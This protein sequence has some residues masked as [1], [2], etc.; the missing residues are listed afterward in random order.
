MSQ[1]R[2]PFM[3]YYRIRKQAELNNV[4]INQRVEI[5][6]KEVVTYDDLYGALEYSLQRLYDATDGVTDVSST[7]INFMLQVLVDKK[8]LTDKELQGFIATMKKLGGTVHDKETD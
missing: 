4:K 6:G 7:F 5:H 2:Y 8:I 1:P 3:D